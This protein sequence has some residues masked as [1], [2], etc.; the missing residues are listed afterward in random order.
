MTTISRSSAC[1]TAKRHIAKWA[2]KQRRPN[3]VAPNA[4][5]ERM[6]VI[7]G[8]PRK[9]ATASAAK[10]GNA[11][12]AARFAIKSTTNRS[13]L[14]KYGRSKADQTQITNRSKCAEGLLALRREQGS[15]LSYLPL[16]TERPRQEFP[17]RSGTTLRTTSAASRDRV[18]R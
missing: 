2:T 14:K 4:A 17:M 15:K 6:G 10:T 16:T 11:R 12:S 3:T 5:M 7:G 13:P 18:K 8:K 9:K 1:S